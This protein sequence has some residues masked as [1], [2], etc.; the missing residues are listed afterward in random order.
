MPRTPERTIAPGIY[1][2]RY[3]ITARVRAGS[4]QHE[5]RLEQTFD[6]DTEL[7]TIKAWQ[8]RA[9]VKLREMGPVVRRGTLA[10]DVEAYLERVKKR[11]ASWKSKRSEL[12][13]WTALLGDRRR[14]QILP[15][16]I[17]RAIATWREQ[18]VALKTI[19]NRCRTLH[20]LYVTLANDKR[21]DT[22]LDNVDV[23]KP[24][25]RKPQFVS[26]TVI[27]RVERKLRAGD[28]FVHAFYMVIA[29]TGLRPSQV[30]RVMQTLTSADVRRGV[31][32]FEGG[33][34]G[35]PIPLVLNAEQKHA[36]EALLKARRPIIP[37]PA[38]GP[39][40]RFMDATK[41]ARLVRAAGWPSDVRPYNARH[42]VGIELA[43]RGAADADIQKQLGHSDVAMIRAHY[44][45][46]RLT[47]MRRV[48]EL[49]EGRLGWGQSARRTTRR[50]GGQKRPKVVKSGQNPKAKKSA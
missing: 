11:P 16:D 12:K 36:F 32:V 10:T 47:T 40:Y 49:L 15:A 14:H 18:G 29:S 42:A 23:P 17:D 1:I 34:G 8:E 25:K 48:S 24:P 5:R 28:P 21:A 43:E 35:E 3:S 9:R 46:V 39:L 19:V 45:G 44:T 31:V 37:A 4:G 27:K 22:P 2:G 20:H 41:Y 33:K 50:T 13:A 30:N 26:A 7:E 6:L 38:T